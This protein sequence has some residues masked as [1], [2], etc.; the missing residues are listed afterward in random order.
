MDLSQ[1]EIN[2]KN[3]QYGSTEAFVSDAKW[4]VHNSY[5]YNSGKK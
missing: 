1:L 2:I 3:Q 4:M 5:I